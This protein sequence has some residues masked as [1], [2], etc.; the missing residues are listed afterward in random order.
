MADVANAHSFNVHWA[1]AVEASGR[2]RRDA[3]L[4]DLDTSISELWLCLNLATDGNSIFRVRQ[5]LGTN[6][7]S[8]YWQRYR[9]TDLTESRGILE[10][11][12][13]QLQSRAP[14]TP[15]AAMHLGGTLRELARASGNGRLLD[16]AIAILKK[17]ERLASRYQSSLDVVTVA[18]VS[19]ELALLYRDRY[20]LTR[21]PRDIRRAIDGHR[22]AHDMLPRFPGLGYE[23]MVGRPRPDKAIFLYS[24][25]ETLRIAA[26]G[27]RTRRRRLALLDRS[28]RL[29]QHACG[30]RS[31]PVALESLG[32][33]IAE[34]SDLATFLDADER[35]RAQQHAVAAFE[36]CY[37][38]GMSVA[39][40]VA[41]SAA[42]AYGEW[43]ASQVHR[44]G[45]GFDRPDPRLEEAARA[46]GMALQAADRIVRTQ[47]VRDDLA[48]SLRGQSGLASDAA[49]VL[50]SAGKTEA[51]AA[52]LEAGRAHLIREALRQDST[53][54][55]RLRELGHEDLAARYEE[56]VD[57]L[58]RV[59]SAAAERE[60]DTV[61]DAIHKV[62]DFHAFLADATLAEVV[63]GLPAESCLVYVLATAW[64]GLALIVSREHTDSVWL[65]DLTRQST[66]DAAIR[67][68]TGVK[69]E[70]PHRQRRLAVRASLEWAGEVVM[71]RVVE[72]IAPRYHRMFLIPIG[73]L[74]AIPLHA[75]IVKMGSRELTFAADYAEIAY[76][77][78]G[79]AHLRTARARR[80]PL[81][82]AVV[83]A[84]PS[85]TSSAADE[86]AVRACIGSNN[87]V[88][89]A[90][91]SQK[92]AVMSL[93]EQ[94]P[95]GHFACHGRA[96]LDD[97]AKSFIELP[98]GGD[99]RLSAGDFWGRRLETSRLIVLASC[100]SALSGIALEDE[101]IGLPSLL[102]Q[103]GVPGV[104]GTLWEVD[105]ATASQVATGFY[106]ALDPAK[107]DLPGSLW[108]ASRPLLSDPDDLLGGRSGI[109]YE[110]AA[111]FVAVG[112]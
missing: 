103:A 2:F 71:Q 92:E 89:S 62:Q 48:D 55:Q 58:T 91:G 80:A 78:N 79:A 37:D 51:G 49:Y 90:L 60:L 77:P 88:L 97:P 93:L 81:T 111:A 86:S 106:S 110:D 5:A 11:A 40:Y 14:A 52:A 108:K 3:R 99:L 7:Q 47:I 35:V 19:D 29:L 27:A 61:V 8:R 15:I 104:V 12:W 50:A 66:Q 24:Y 69:K 16:E 75:G 98:G 21:K 109:R 38:R 42:R 87:V 63:A 85:L 23:L 76:L 94:H 67:L 59:D 32:K 4:V 46:Y 45:R 83:V 28:I 107:P 22:R 54:L 53:D 112:G 30:M 74:A 31:D 65:P 1:A 95:L 13:R 56:A 20:Q 43:L 84:T 105:D 96:V 6:Y 100:E 102:L 73:R 26:S 64:G 39:P 101:A 9:L 34:Y 82:S 70:V 72:R 25:G 18:G 68:R 17:G 41:R 57:G 44:T 33:A 10:A 36:T